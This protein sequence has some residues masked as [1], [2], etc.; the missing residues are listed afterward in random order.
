[1]A[2]Q[3]IGNKLNITLPAYLDTLEKFDHRSGRNIKEQFTVSESNIIQLNDVQVEA[4]FDGIPVD[5][6]GKVG[7]FQ[8]V[9]YIT[10]PGRKVPTELFN[11]LKTHCGIVSVSLNELPAKFRHVTKTG[12]SYRSTL[13]K[14][15]SKD[16]M[17]KH[18]IFHPRYQRS[19][20]NA[21]QRLNARVSEFNQMPKISPAKA[22][23]IIDRYME[24]KKRLALFECVMCH[25]QWQ[26][27]DPGI[28]ECPKCK[29]HLYSVCKEYLD[30]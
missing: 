8:F 18:W 24:S 2:R 5:I 30:E 17:S 26:A 3:I 22:I 19:K 1:M 9:I 7:D 13:L 23:G 10:H 16:L 25:E 14:F 20:E 28:N 6:I 12:I 29:T 27:M 11:P 15:L 4:M 21:Q